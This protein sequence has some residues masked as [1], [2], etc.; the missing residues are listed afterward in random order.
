MCWREKITRS[1]ILDDGKGW[2]EELEREKVKSLNVEP[3]G[4]CL[5]RHDPSLLPTSFFRKLSF[6][7]SDVEFGVRK[8][9]NS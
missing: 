3:R 5:G 8:G 7:I 1:S 4:L 6:Q 2:F 9:G